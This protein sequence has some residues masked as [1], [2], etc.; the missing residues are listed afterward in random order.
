M[1]KQY[2]LINKLTAKPGRRDEVIKILLESG[3]PFQDDPACLFSLVYEDA[4]DPNVIWVEDL[5]A[6][7]RDHAAALARPEMKPF[8]ARAIPLLQGLPEQTEINLIGGKGLTS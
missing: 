5:W 3:K 7:K 8:I 1:D 6:T 2:A 4:K